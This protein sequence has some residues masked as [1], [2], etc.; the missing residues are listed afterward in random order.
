MFR[1]MRRH[2]DDRRVRAEVTIQDE[3]GNV[4]FQGE[5]RDDTADLN[6]HESALLPIGRSYEASGR[7]GEEEARFS[8]RAEP[9]MK[10]ILLTFQ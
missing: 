10:P 1:P 9:G 3:Q 6:D 5:T 8:F 4:V 7:I 2:H